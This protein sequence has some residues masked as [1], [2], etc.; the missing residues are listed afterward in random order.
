MAIYVFG[1]GVYDYIGAL[2]EWGGV[3]WREESVVN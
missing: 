3:E 2:E 1:K